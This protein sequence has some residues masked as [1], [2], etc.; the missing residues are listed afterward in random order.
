MPENLTVGP[1]GVPEMEAGID[2]PT[3]ADAPQS[4]LGQAGDLI[5]VEGVGKVPKAEVAK[6]YKDMTAWRRDQAERGRVLNQRETY[7]SQVAEEM[8]P[9]VQLKETVFDQHPGSRERLTR[10]LQSREFFYGEPSYAPSTGGQP[11]QTGAAPQ[12]PR[13]GRGEELQRLREEFDAYRYN[14]E[15]ASAWQVFKNQSPVSPIEEAA[16]RF[17]IDQGYIPS[18]GL[19]DVQVLHEAKRFVDGMTQ[20]EK[21]QAAGQTISD[22]RRAA[23]AGSTEAPGRMTA[24]MRQPPNLASKDIDQCIA[25]GLAAIERGDYAGLTE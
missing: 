22:I 2:V 4:T 24:G 17:F 13:D 18:S 16:M 10:F 9:L 19:S 20:Q 6:A 5:E 7:L 25:D 21:A 15:A 1:D 12:A 3:G 11:P 14:Q 23:L 8:A